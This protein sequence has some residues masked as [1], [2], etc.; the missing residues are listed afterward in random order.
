MCKVQLCCVKPRD[1]AREIGRYRASLAA[2]RME[3]VV[4]GDTLAEHDVAH[5]AHTLLAVEPAGAGPGDHQF[6]VV[7]E[8][9]VSLVQLVPDS[10]SVADKV[11]SFAHQINR[12][13]N[14]LKTLLADRDAKM[15]TVHSGD[16][17]DLPKVP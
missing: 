6:Q 14:I 15:K 13:T 5:R 16:S 9:D 17:A 12:T 10:A 4:V 8:V 2:Q 11:V 1:A 7:P 3:N